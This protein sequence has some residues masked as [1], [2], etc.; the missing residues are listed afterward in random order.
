[1]PNEPILQF[2]EH[3]LFEKYRKKWCILFPVQVNEIK[4][5]ARLLKK[6][7]TTDVN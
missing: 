3:N 6:K 7:K 2:C 5:S 1:M 4:N